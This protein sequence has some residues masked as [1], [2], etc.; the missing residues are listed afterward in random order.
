MSSAKMVSGENNQL[1]KQQLELLLHAT[2]ADAS[3]PP[4]TTQRPLASERRSIQPGRVRPQTGKRSI[5]SKAS[6]KDASVVSSIIGNMYTP[7]TTARTRSRSGSEFNGGS[8][9]ITQNTK[10]PCSSAGSKVSGLSRASSRASSL[11]S[12]GSGRPTTSEVLLAKKQ[13]KMEGM[14]RKLLVQQQEADCTIAELSEALTRLDP[15][16]RDR[17][18]L[19]E[20]TAAVREGKK[21]NPIGKGGQ[22]LGIQHLNGAPQ[23]GSLKRASPWHLRRGDP[24]QDIVMTVHPDGNTEPPTNRSTTSRR[25][26]ELEGR[27]TKSLLA[28]ASLF[29]D[30]GIKGQG[31]TI[32]AAWSISDSPNNNPTNIL[33]LK[34][35][36]YV[37]PS[38]PKHFDSRSVA[39]S[40]NKWGSEEQANQWEN[41]SDKWHTSTEDVHGYSNFNP[42][43][44]PK[45]TTS[46]RGSHRGA[47]RPNSALSMASTRKASKLSRPASA[48][49]ATY[50][51]DTDPELKSNPSLWTGAGYGGEVYARLGAQ[52]SELYGRDKHDPEILAQ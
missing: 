52:N 42:G 30:K 27:M 15:A 18:D 21:M 29:K 40:L 10:V 25:H 13:L 36:R 8:T 11:M 22:M 12:G 4:L 34:K 14:I 6:R 28:P 35:E 26:S 50:F 7:S 19:H 17:I 24:S 23:E 32:A 49:P 43:N 44:T 47:H 41:S 3:N 2:A 31:G 51:G 45:R 39:H 33:N 38:V 20:M 9:Q 48:V 5:A 1:P 46:R 16:E 37:A